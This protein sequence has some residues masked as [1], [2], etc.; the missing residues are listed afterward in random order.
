MSK[1]ST[2]PLLKTKASLDEKIESC[3]G[4]GFTWHGFFQAFMVSFAWFFDAQQS[5]I[6]VFTDAEP[7][8]NSPAN[9][10]TVSEWLSTSTGSIISGMPASSFYM[11]CLIGGLVL[12]TLA[13]THV[14][15]KN[16]L[17][18]S[19]FSMGLTGLL[20]M[21]SPNIWIYIIL[22][23]LSGFCRATIGTCSLVLATELVGRKWRGRA[24]IIGF[25]CFTFGFLSLP[26]LAYLNI[27]S[28]WRLLYLYTNL[29]AIIYSIMVHYLVCESPRWLYV[30]GKKEQFIETLQTMAKPENQ[31]SLTLSFFG[32]LV[33]CQSSYSEGENLYS[34]LKI[35]WEKKW[36]FRRL[37][38]VMIVGFGMGI[39]YYGMPLGLGNLSYNLYL[40]VT[41]NAISEIP[42]SL[43]TFFCVDK[44]N[45]RSSLLCFCLLSGICS[46][47]CVM[48]NDEK[49]KELQIGLEL[50]SFFSACT[51]FD[52][53]LI[54]TMELFPTCVRNSALSV[55]RQ[56][57][58]LGGVFSPIL[59]AAGRKNVFLSFGVFG[60]TI[61]ICGL[62]VLCLPE[63]R[64]RMFCDTMDEE[65][66][67]MNC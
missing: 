34:A 15:R 23:F 17:V 53:V 14:G 21:L 31:S 35:L 44:L 20:T 30:K 1:S 2:I 43:V 32:S 5:F 27:G 37:V 63:T 10:S 6:S 66:H 45:R 19:C 40:S 51:A 42:A 58:V 64:G 18:L 67:N 12:A 26:L 25:F 56:A 54:Y 33:E 22:R 7:Q 28:S 9:A 62:F 24:G 38:A 49:W 4:S 57:L 55:V 60:V 52:V 50:V 36:A 61:G 48:V 59:V 41:L 65:E 46:V 8:T 3:I 39:V 13:D 11:G 47:M 29:P 16:M